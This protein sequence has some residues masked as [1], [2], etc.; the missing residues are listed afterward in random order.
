LAGFGKEA[1]HPPSDFGDPGSF[2][3]LDPEGK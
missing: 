1:M 2:G 3:N